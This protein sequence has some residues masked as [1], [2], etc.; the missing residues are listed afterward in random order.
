MQEE[1]AVAD[2]FITF[3]AATFVVDTGTPKKKSFNFVLKFFSPEKCDIFYSIWLVKIFFI[4]N[5]LINS[6]G[7][8]TSPKISNCLKA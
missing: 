3:P 6:C 7:S 1:G 8:H 2:I 5:C 4:S